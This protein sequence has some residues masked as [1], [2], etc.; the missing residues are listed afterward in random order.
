MKQSELSD[1]ILLRL[2]DLGNKVQENNTQHINHEN[3]LND[4]DEKVDSIAQGIEE[5]KAGPVYALDGYIKHQVVKYTGGLGLL[6]LLI[7]LG[8]GGVL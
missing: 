3:R 6:G 1:L 4:L 2:D 5:I 7:M 8:T